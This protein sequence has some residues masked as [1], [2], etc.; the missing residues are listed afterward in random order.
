MS[1][2]VTRYAQ[3]ADRAWSLPVIAFACTG[4]A[5]FTVVGALRRL[6]MVGSEVTNESAAATAALGWLDW[7]LAWAAFAACLLAADAGAAIPG[8]AKVFF[9]GQSIGLVSLVP[10]GLGAS[11]AWWMLHLDGSAPG[12][13]SAVLA[14]RVLYYLLPGALGSVAMFTTAADRRRQITPI[15]APDPSH[16]PVIPKCV[17]RR[18]V[19]GGAAASGLA[20]DGAA[21][22]LAVS[23]PRPAPPQKSLRQRQES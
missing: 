3:V 13:V 23:S 4:A 11:D 15:P 21:V 18:S 5:A 1:A 8:S 6:R 20:V 14:Y 22:V 2:W 7:G 9:L 12:I 16:R 19:T 17:S 10:G